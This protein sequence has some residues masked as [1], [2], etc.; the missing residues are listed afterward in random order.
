MIL[1]ITKENHIYSHAAGA[2][3]SF[4]ASVAVTGAF[5]GP[6]S[7]CGCPFSSL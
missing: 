1:Y 2:T 6:A 3:T 4:G 7:L 5:F